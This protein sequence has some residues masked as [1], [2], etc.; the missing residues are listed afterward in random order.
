MEQERK[1]SQPLFLQFENTQIPEFKE[2]RS[3]D[4]VYYG[5]N[6]LWTDYIIELYQRS[7]K[8]NAIVNGKVNYI[9]GGG[10]KPST[11][12]WVEKVN[13]YETLKDLSLK[14]TCDLELF[15][16]YAIE[17]I[18]NMKGGISEMYHIDFSKLRT[19]KDET[20]Y[21]Y[22]EDWTI[23]VQDS[24][25]E[26][27]NYKEFE[28][29]DFQSKKK[30]KTKQ[31]YVFKIKTPRKNGEPN[32]YPIPE[33]MGALS[34]IETDVEISNFHLTNI[35]TGFSAGTMINL[36]NGQPTDE[37]ARKLERKFNEKYT[38]T[39]NAAKIMLNFAIDKEHAAE[40]VH[41]QPS[42]MDKQYLQMAER[43]NQEIF[44]GHK[45]TPVLFGV[46]T[47]GALGQRNEMLDAY[48]LF[49]SI[50]IDIRQ[51][52]LEDCFNKLAGLSGLPQDIEIIKTKPLTVGI[53][54]VVLQQAITVDE[55]R[56][57]LGLPKLVKPIVTTSPTQ[58]AKVKPTED[59]VI[60]EFSKFGFSK[61]GFSV[62]KTRECKFNSIKDFVIQDEVAKELFA[63]EDITTPSD[64]DIEGGTIKPVALKV[65]Y[66]YEWRSEVPA[67]KRDTTAHPSR[68]FCQKLMDLNRYYKRS[69]LETIS[70]NIGYN[71]FTH[72]GGFWND[73]GNI[74]DHCR[75]KWVQH[76]VTNK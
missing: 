43:V 24:N 12:P 20:K 41:M 61:E 14:L 13:E 62:I 56:E 68:P 8:H 33:Y 27:T 47:S 66:T 70:D 71:V 34:A 76:I 26:K 5:E 39:N 49:Q 18:Y 15:N 67:S 11:N 16:G 36:L 1:Y 50:Y 37:E 31:I 63:D 44:T 21:Y 23:K 32:V 10:Y 59:E 75:H 46:M 42:D 4:W 72:T 25:L 9:I 45:V 53:P 69:D 19:N 2:V 7:A 54:D 29:F 74:K 73:N 60:N 17:I 40:V 38:G 6:N 35:K 51:G 64:E 65:V 30:S 57:M 58:M 3:K 48:E 52:I 22:S 28:A 55:A